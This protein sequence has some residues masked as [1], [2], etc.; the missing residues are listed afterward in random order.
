M[1][2][3]Q[4]HRAG[5]GVTR[6]DAHRQPADRSH[7]DQI[8]QAGPAYLMSE[9]FDERAVGWREQ[10]MPPRFPPI[11]AASVIPDRHHESAA[12]WN[13]RV[14]SVSG[15]GSGGIE[16]VGVTGQVA[17]GIPARFPVGNQHISNGFGVRRNQRLARGWT[18][19]GS[20]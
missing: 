3:I 13:D 11:D 16:A 19:Q 14:P 17:T 18:G 5:G 10:R 15:Q 6:G 2:H 8:Q 4:Y 20:Y 7:W 9:Q 1:P 12:R